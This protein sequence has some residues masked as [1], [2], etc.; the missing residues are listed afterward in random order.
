MVLPAARPA[1]PG[2]SAAISLRACY[3]MS[4]AD[5]ASGSAYLRCLRIV[6]PAARAA[7]LGRS[8][9]ISLRACYAMSG[10]EL[11]YGAISL[12]ARLLMCGTQGLV[13]Y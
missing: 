10:T 9:D 6:R 2:M 11:A 1:G 4:S 12:C 5:L 8:A 13:W 3:A 7:K